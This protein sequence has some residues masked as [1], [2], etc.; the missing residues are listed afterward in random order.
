MNFSIKWRYIDLCSQ[1]HIQLWRDAA[2]VKSNPERSCHELKR[3][4]S[5]ITHVNLLLI[6][7]FDRCLRTI[8][9]PP[10]LAR[11]APTVLLTWIQ[12]ERYASSRSLPSFQLP[13]LP[14]GAN[15]GHDHSDGQQNGHQR[16]GQD[17]SKVL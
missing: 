14:N 11:V 7:V 12:L 5:E 2:K 1:L 6:R 16:P 3:R 10:G 13:A 9:F 8:L 15:Y 17:D 4:Q